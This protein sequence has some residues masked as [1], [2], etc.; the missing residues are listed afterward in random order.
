MFQ[1]T[2][3]NVLYLSLGFISHVISSPIALPAPQAVTA[4]ISPVAPQREGCTGDVLG[5]FGIAVMNV[6]IS[7]SRTTLQERQVGYVFLLS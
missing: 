7:T 3:S 2:K 5:V 1:I 4:L 6:S